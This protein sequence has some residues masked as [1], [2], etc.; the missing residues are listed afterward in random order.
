MV[1][2]LKVLPRIL[3]NCLITFYSVTKL[4]WWRIGLPVCPGQWCGSG[5]VKLDLD[6]SIRDPGSGYKFFHYG[7]WIRIGRAE[8][9]K[10]LSWTKQIVT[11]LS[12]IWSEMFIPDP[13]S[14]GQKI[15]DPG[16]GSVTLGL[17][18]VHLVQNDTLTKHFNHLW[19]LYHLKLFWTVDKVGSVFFFQN[20]R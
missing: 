10:N 7:S 1:S 9:T 13:W 14:M 4:S 3:E 12:E 17:G 19:F 16:S 18:M 5:M 2:V 11:K 6:F 20:E 8:F 15:L